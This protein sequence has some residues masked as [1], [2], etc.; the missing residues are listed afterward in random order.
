MDTS[1]SE[2]IGWKG[3][4]VGLQ[5]MQRSCSLAQSF[6]LEQV[7]KQLRS[8]CR[9]HPKRCRASL[10]KKLENRSHKNLRKFDKGKQALHMAPSNPITV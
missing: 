9:E 5:S 1:S 3:E 7:I 8:S 2:K 4:D 10:E 6:A